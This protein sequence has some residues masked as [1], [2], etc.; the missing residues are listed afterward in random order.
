MDTDWKSYTRFFNESWAELERKFRNGVIDPQTETDV[1]CYLYHALAK[2]FE[3]KG[4]P[5][6]VIK[7]ED[8]RQIKKQT[9]IPDLNLNDRLFIE[10]KIWTLRKYDKG[11]ASRKKAI[12]YYADKLEEY[13]TDTKAR[14]SFKV[15][16]PILAIWFW[17]NPKRKILSFDEKLIHP[18][19]QEKLENERARFQGRINIVYGPRR[20]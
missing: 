3:K 10:V 2:R 16:C 14:T 6:S 15:R 11:W 1:V 9:L 12:A 7:T 17:K 8:T 4:W 18:D 13:V 20:Q 5:L 19:L